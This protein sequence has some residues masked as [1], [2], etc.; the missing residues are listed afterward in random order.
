MDC[1]RPTRL[2]RGW[3]CV[4][5]ANVGDLGTAAMAQSQCSRRAIC[6]C[7]THPTCIPFTYPYIQCPLTSRLILAPAS[8]A[9]ARECCRAAAA[10]SRCRQHHFATG[11]YFSSEYFGCWHSAPHNLRPYSAVDIQPPACR[12]R[13]RTR[14]GMAVVAV[15]AAVVNSTPAV[16]RS[17][18]KTGVAAAMATA[19]IQ[20]MLMAWMAQSQRLVVQVLD[21]TWPCGTSTN[22]T[23]SAV[24]AGSSAGWVCAAGVMLF[25]TSRLTTRMRRSHSHSEAWGR[26]PWHCAVSYGDAICVC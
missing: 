23:R 5:S 15:A 6:G 13:E 19:P 12:R 18:G 4:A 14:E 25:V 8:F 24:Q 26:V 16:A 20:A 1:L 22:A 2:W 21:C 10:G 3:P 9:H 7:P 17:H 11:A